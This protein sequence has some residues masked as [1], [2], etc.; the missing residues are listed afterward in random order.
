MSNLTL[1]T[2]FQYHQRDP[3]TNDYLLEDVLIIT[4]NGQ[5]FREGINT[6]TSRPD[7]VAGE[8]AYRE[9]AA[10]LGAALGR[11]GAMI[12]GYAPYLEKGEQ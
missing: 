4:V 5:V 2:T 8:F 1:D 7:G 3:Y 9:R 12:E 11:L 10:R 6:V